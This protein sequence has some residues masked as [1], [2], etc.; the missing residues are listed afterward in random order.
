MV[1]LRL[2]MVARMVLDSF[3]VP[4]HVQLLLNDQCKSL[5]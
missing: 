2:P 5:T 4:Q 3:D 1:N